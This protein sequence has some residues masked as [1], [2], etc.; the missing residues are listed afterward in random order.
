MVRPERDGDPSEITFFSWEAARPWAIGAL[1]AIPVM[2]TVGLLGP[3]WLSERTVHDLGVALGL[4]LVLV[5][6]ARVAGL[7]RVPM[8]WTVLGYLALVALFLGVQ[9]VLRAIGATS[10]R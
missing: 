5:V 8:H 9:W 10:G 7:S 1:A 2:I 6:R 3:L 4:P